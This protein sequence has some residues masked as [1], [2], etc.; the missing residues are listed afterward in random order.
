M[1]IQFDS[2]P[3]SNPF[4]LPTPDVYKAKITEAV[5]KKGKDENKPPYLNL[6]LALVNAQGKACGSIYDIMAES[7]SSVV[8][9]KLGRF[10][11]A[12]GIPLQGSMELSDIY[13]LVINK[14]IVVDVNHD[15]KSQQPRA[16][17]DLFTREA[18]YPVGQFEEIYNLA[19]MNDE[20]VKPD[21]NSFINPPEAADGST[22]VEY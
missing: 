14:E 17:V 4:A 20:A 2:L 3:K 6:K 11:L 22:E 19:H 13:K 10:L 7:D 8:Q 5:M 18:Y 12:C 15:T 21:V 9:Y 1:A 16:Q